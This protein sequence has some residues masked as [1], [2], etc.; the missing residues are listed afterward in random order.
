[1]SINISHLDFLHIFYG[2][3]L[4]WGSLILF[5]RKLVLKHLSRWLFILNTYAFIHEYRPRQQSE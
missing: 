2:I 5:R 1:M 4:F 3:F